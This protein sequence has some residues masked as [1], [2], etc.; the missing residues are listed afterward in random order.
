[1]PTATDTLASIMGS[2]VTTS[3]SLLTTVIT[4]YWP[5]VLVFGILAALIGLFTKFAHLGTGRHK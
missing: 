2:V 1:M 3:V 4:T 5:Y